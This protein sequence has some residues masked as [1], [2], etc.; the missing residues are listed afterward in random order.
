MEYY[1]ALD[2][3]L[4]ADDENE[5]KTRKTQ[6][7][8]V[9]KK[10]TKTHIR[11]NAHMPLL[12]KL[13]CGLHIL[14]HARARHDDGQA[15]PGEL[16]HRQFLHGRQRGRGRGQEAHRVQFGQKEVGV[17]RSGAGGGELGDEVG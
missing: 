10:K 11:P 13:D 7:K 12:H 2:L 14:H 4:A 17:L 9:I 15:P 5:I 3:S 8:S 1:D 16:G 6:R